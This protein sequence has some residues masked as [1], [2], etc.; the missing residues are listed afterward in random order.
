ME[1]LGCLAERDGARI[2]VFGPSL[3]NSRVWLTAYPAGATLLFAEGQNKEGYD[4]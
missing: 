2:G 4:K 3:F 1:R